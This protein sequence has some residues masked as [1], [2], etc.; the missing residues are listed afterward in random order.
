MSG[1]GPAGGT[2]TGG[3]CPRP[4]P[5]SSHLF[6]STDRPWPCRVRVTSRAS[7]H[8]KAEDRALTGLKKYTH[9]RHT[10]VR[11][12][13]V[14]QDCPCASYSTLMQ[15]QEPEKNDTETGRL[16]AATAAD[17]GPGKW[18]PGTH[19]RGRSVGESGICGTGTGASGKGR[20]WGHRYR[21]EGSVTGR[22]GR[23]SPSVS[24][25]D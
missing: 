4:A 16:P 1:P 8:L 19:T 25:R 21:R 15:G 6:L 23:R 7:G 9:N 10:C 17:G 24:G 12:T 3:G 5:I 13:R 20:S 18:P 11:L 14:S 2:Q 22:R